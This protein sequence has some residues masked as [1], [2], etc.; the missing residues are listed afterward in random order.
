[1]PVPVQVF[2]PQQLTAAM[3]LGGESRLLHYDLRVP[4]HG[5]VH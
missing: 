5:Q 1:M 3:K 2:A 4:L